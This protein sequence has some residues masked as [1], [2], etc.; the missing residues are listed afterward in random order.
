MRDKEVQ[1]MHKA[2]IKAWKSKLQRDDRETYRWLKGGI[3]DKGA[4]MRMP[5]GSHNAH[6]GT[7]LRAVQ[8]AWRPIYEK[9][10]DSIFEKQAFDSILGSKTRAAK[11]T[12]HPH[13]ARGI[14]RRSNQSEA[15]SCRP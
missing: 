15:V 3:V 14:D 1:D 5:D 13:Y 4:V 7:Q 6:V 2:R 9:H 12:L 8:E 10:K 11:Q